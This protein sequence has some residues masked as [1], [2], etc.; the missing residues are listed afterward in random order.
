[1]TGEDVYQGGTKLEAPRTLFPCGDRVVCVEFCKMVMVVGDFGV[2]GADGIGDGLDLRGQGGRAG[3]A[4]QIVPAVPRT[5]AH[6][7]W[8]AIASLP[9][10]GQVGRWPVAADTPVEPAQ[11]AGGLTA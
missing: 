7:L 9:A 11:I 5:K 4:E 6:Q 1:L 8:P 2:T 3:D 10:E